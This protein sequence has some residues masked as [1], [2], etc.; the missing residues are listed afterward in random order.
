MEFN[1]IEV[2]R[3]KIIKLIDLFSGCEGLD[4]DLFSGCGG[5]D[6]EQSTTWKR[7]TLRVAKDLSDSLWET[8]E[9]LKDKKELYFPVWEEELNDMPGEEKYSV[10]ANLEDLPR[11]GKAEMTQKIVRY[12][13]GLGYPV[14]R[15]FIGRAEVWVPKEDTDS[16]ITY[17][18]YTLRPYH[19]DLTD[20]WQIDISHSGESRACKKTLYDVE[21]EDHGYDVVAGTEILDRRNVKQRH[22]QKFGGGHPVINKY[23]SKILHIEKPGNYDRNKYKTK[24]D[25]IKGFIRKYLFTQEFQNALDIDILNGGDLIKVRPEEIYMVGDKARNL[26]YGSNH[27][28]RTPKTDFS[29]YGPFLRPQSYKYF[30]ICPKGCEEAGNRLFN[31]LQWG[32]DSPNKLTDEEKEQGTGQRYKQLGKFLCQPTRWVNY[33]SLLYSSHEK[34]MEELERH[35]KEESRFEKDSKYIAL[36]ISDIHRDSPDS[37]LHELYYRMKELLMKYGVTSQVIY[38]RN[39]GKDNFNFFLPNIAAAITAKE[40][41]MPWALESLTRRNDMIVGIGASKQHGLKPYLGTA[42][43]FDKIGQ[44]REF[45]CCQAEDTE[46]LGT[47]LKKALWQ[48]CNEYGKPERLIIHYYKKLRHDEGEQIEDILLQNDIQCPVYVVNIVTAENEDLIAFDPSQWNLMPK[49]GTFVHLR[50]TQ[51]LLYNNEKYNDNG[52]AKVLFPIKLSIASTHTNTG[53]ILTK[54]DYVDI[55]TQVYQFCRLYW[56]SVSMQNVPI[57]IAYPELVAQFVPH[58]RDGELPDFGKHNL[59]ML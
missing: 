42:F 26:I 8:N 41:G 36:I 40:S 3:R 25:K 10:M 16:Y 50:D 35:L 29:L 4:F 52:K 30:F 39:I 48:F 19:H 44:F 32:I 27:T 17:D 43:C 57:T 34:A 6:L 46:A 59:W 37:R 23:T 22:F 14:R 58:F 20:G 1:C 21:L 55:I 33:L 38:A 11:I 47:S 49:S 2:V 54:E 56:K 24:M 9:C 51:F 15:D 12:F 31:I 53:G 18:K 13:R 5:L 7:A 45:D 28:G